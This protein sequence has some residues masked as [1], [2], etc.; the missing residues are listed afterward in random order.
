MATEPNPEFLAEYMAAEHGTKVL[1]TN[2]KADYYLEQ[3][4]LGKKSEIPEKYS[5]WCGGVGG[6]DDYTE[7]MN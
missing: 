2:P 3:A 4:R 5:R 1:I 6:F 7:R